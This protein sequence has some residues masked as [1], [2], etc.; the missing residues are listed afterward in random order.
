MPKCL[1]S[2]NI[3][4]QRRA[5]YPSS[6]LFSQRRAFVLPSA[7][8]LT[9]ASNFLLRAKLLNSASKEGTGIP[10]RSQNN[11]SL[12]EGG[13]PQGGPSRIAAFLGPP[14]HPRSLSCARSLAYGAPFVE[15][16]RPLSRRLPARRAILLGGAHS[17]LWFAV[18]LPLQSLLCPCLSFL[19]RPPADT[20]CMLC[21]SEAFVLAVEVSSCAAASAQTWFAHLHSSALTRA[22]WL[23]SGRKKMRRSPC[24]AGCRWRRKCGRPPQACRRAPSAARVRNSPPIHDR[25]RVEI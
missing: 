4:T 9:T 8:L 13:S 16:L 19:L 2:V 18:S 17:T 20:T 6:H 23:A 24:L 1:L 14:Q 25:V 12:V 22:S 3:F 7:E 5:S 15:L 11:P 21:S 10:T